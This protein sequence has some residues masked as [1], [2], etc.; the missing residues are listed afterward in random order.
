MRELAA[1]VARELQEWRRIF[2]AALAGGFLV[3]L[4]PLIPGT[5][6]HSPLQAVDAMSGFMS[7]AFGLGVAILAGGG[8]IGRELAER[9]MGFYFFR[10]LRDGSIWGGKMLAAVFLAFF[11]AVLVLVPPM[12]VGRGLLGLRHEETQRA[13]ALLGALIVAL[14][15]LGNSI[16]LTFRS[17]SKWALLDLVALLVLAGFLSIA[18]YPLMQGLA[19]RLSRLLIAGFVLLFLLALAV[20]GYAG[21]RRGRTDLRQV[22]KYHALA[23]WPVLGVAA[24][25]LLAYSFWVRSAGPR[26]FTSPYVAAA[27]PTGSWLAVS[28]RSEYRADYQPA[29]LMNVETGER[30]RLPGGRL[31]ADSVAISQDGRRAIWLEPIGV[32]AFRGRVTVTSL[33]RKPRSQATAIFASRS[34]EI[35]LSSDGS[36]IA[37]MSGRTVSVLDLESERALASARIPGDRSFFRRVF[38]VQPNLIRLYDRATA[39]TLKIFEFDI[40]N[41]KLEETGSVDSDEHL[42][43]SIPAGGPLALRLPQTGQVQLRDARTGRILVETTMSKTEQSMMGF[44]SDGRLVIAGVTDGQAQLS[45]FSPDGTIRKTIELGSAGT[46]RLGGQPEQGSLVVATSP[47]DRSADPRDYRKT[48]TLFLVDLESGKI[49][50]VGSQMSPLSYLWWYTGH[51]PAPGSVATRLFITADHQ[52]VYFDPIAGQRRVIAGRGAEL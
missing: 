8:L 1:V 47:E 10:P 15:V 52:I 17:R 34:D 7:T 35:T 19:L 37:L 11:S 20:A 50:P 27:A 44:L 5:K 23:L 28:G 41:K 12:L 26:D 43:Y 6:G 24:I 31:T 46:V 38:F 49:R 3:L 51:L 30:L 2:V 22:H 9:R 45:I 4:A 25:A 39:T 13:I 36:Q 29:L 21:I 33:G 14:V 42:H 16:H 40:Q 48:L 32:K 18:I